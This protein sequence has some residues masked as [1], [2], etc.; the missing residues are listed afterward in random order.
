MK[1]IEDTNKWKVLLYSRIGE[2]ILLKCPYT[3]QSNL[4]IRWNSYQNTN[5]IFHR[6]RTNN[7]KIV[8][9]HKRLQTA[10]AI[11]KKNKAGDTTIPDFKLCYKAIVSRQHG[12]GTI[13]TSINGTD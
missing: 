5:G 6:T 12:T 13:D 3:M 4:Q 11:L 9:N 1:E 2:L 10:K 7:T 8:W